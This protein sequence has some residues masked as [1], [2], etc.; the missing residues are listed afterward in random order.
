MH[1][2]IVSIL[3]DS[4]L[5][6]V[7]LLSMP[8]VSGVDGG[9]TQREARLCRERPGALVVR[10]RAQVSQERGGESNEGGTGDPCHPSQ[11]PATCV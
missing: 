1:G 2:H 8:V 3:S 5:W 10:A 11:V 9:D 7:R 4:T 6:P